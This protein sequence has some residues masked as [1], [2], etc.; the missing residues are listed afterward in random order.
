[1]NE[2]RAAGVS[3]S[4]SIGV[5]ANSDGDSDTHKQ[6]GKSCLKGCQKGGNAV[7]ER[8]GKSRSGRAKG[9]SSERE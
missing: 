5:G 3:V 2:W 8:V 4:A 1:M 6:S 7:R 9:K